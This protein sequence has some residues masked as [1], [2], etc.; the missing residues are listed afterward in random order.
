MTFAFHPEAG[1]ELAEAADWYEDQS[2]G[3]GDRFLAAVDHAVSIIQ[4]D[5]E[6]FPSLDGA[7]RVYRMKIY[8]Y[9]IFYTC[10]QNLEALYIFAVS[11]KRRRPEYWLERVS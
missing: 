8:P 4:S 5:P 1:L 2:F 7:I 9:K 11:H 6:R 3:L 10:D